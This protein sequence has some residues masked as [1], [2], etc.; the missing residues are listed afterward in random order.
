MSRI[1][2]REML[3]PLVPLAPE[4]VMVLCDLMVS[5]CKR[6]SLLFVEVVPV[7]ENFVEAA[8]CVAENDDADS[9]LSQPA[10]RED[11]A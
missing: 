4:R 8:N 10:K 9:T 1:A 11:I 5:D 3:R 7:G 2:A 6:W